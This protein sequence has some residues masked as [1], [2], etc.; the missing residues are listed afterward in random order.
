MEEDEKST[1]VGSNHEASSSQ[2]G[3]AGSDKDRSDKDRSDNRKASPS[4]SNGPR[5]QEVS[6]VQADI[7]PPA[8]EEAWGDQTTAM[9]RNIP[10]KYTQ[11]KLMREIN[12]AGFLGHFD[13]LYLPMDPRSKVNR[14]F[15]FCNFDSAESAK[16]F[17]KL[18]HRKKLRHFSSDKVVEVVPADIQGFDGNAEHYMAAQAMG[19]IRSNSRPLFMR[20]L[21]L[22]LLAEE[23][24]ANKSRMGQGMANGMMYGMP[25][26]GVPGVPVNYDTSGNSGM[27]FVAPFAAHSRAL[28]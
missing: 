11:A 25:F 15:A 24:E 18:F 17:F 10:S 12:G 8:P 16:R 23:T 26:Q 14:G 1:D 2:E 28:S 19:R 4:I 9:L 6:K 7:C 20:P 22:H 5:S 3:D 21:P 27:F 13:F